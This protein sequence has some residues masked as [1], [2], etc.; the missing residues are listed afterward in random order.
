MA[1]AVIT[2]KQWSSK[3][4][5]PYL[6]G[7]FAPIDRVQQLKPCSYSGSIP[8]EL[9]GGEY[10]RNGGN[11]VQNQD[12]GR[13]AH[14]FDGD[15]MLSGVLFRKGKDGLIQP[16]F[17]NKYVLTDIY[18]STVGTPLLR[19]P[20]VPSIATLVN[21]ASSMLLLIFRILRTML[22]VLLSHLPGS[23]QAIKRLSPA[24]TALVFHDGRALAT[25]EL[26]PPIRVS[27]PSLETVGWFDG[28]KV[29]GE[30]A[31]AED[32]DPKFA[33]HGLFGFM[34][35]WTT[36]HPRVDPATNE[37]I[38]FHPNFKAPFVH[39][40]VLPDTS[41]AP[42]GT[43]SSRLV[44]AAVP[45][46]KSPKMMHDFGVSATHTVIMDLPLALDPRNIARGQPVVVYDP[47]GISRFGVFPRWNP[48]AVRW[49]ETNPCCIFHTANTW[50]EI[51]VNPHTKQ[52][53]IAAVNMLGCRLTSSALVFNAGNIATPIIKASSIYVQE[54]EQCRL[55]YYRFSLSD[56]GNKITHQFSLSAVPFE[57]PSL[58]ASAEMN[59]ARYIYGCSVS[60]RSYGAALGRAVK[61][62]SL[63]K[64][65]V[66]TLISR[67]KKSPPTSIIGCVDHRSVPEILASTDPE[68]PI[69]IFKLPRGLYA[70]ES[71]FV[72]RENGDSEDDGWLLFYVFD[73]SQLDK[74]GN[75]V[76]D[77]RSELWVL[78][79]KEMNEVVCKVQLPQRVPYGLHGKWFPESQILKQRP[80]ETLRHIP[81]PEKRGL[82]IGTGIWKRTREMI[83][84][85]VG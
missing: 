66:K 30:P 14:W 40:S 72:P 16:E 64:M 20:I 33:G 1:H 80:L 11:P 59:A 76:L 28:S 29:E 61:I 53:E 84:K 82:G 62:D 73:E 54:E 8:T 83:L 44:S 79:A 45:G 68:E 47:S 39:Y 48:Q 70:Q 49:F 78:E 19:Q 7:N 27:L 42:S 57:F 25:S 77:A 85:A 26:G 55:Y 81:V 32:P 15:G 43:K 24:N 6:E 41:I 58:R 10:V 38:L 56:F 31:R 23:R 37:L 65:D 46:I 69:K 13:D 17:V 75:A 60:D 36:A 18:I 22:L 2:E 5:H 52:N 63:V 67:A 34:E 9:A 50:D 71:Q 35:E 51:V 12:L 4:P 21:P 74:D 3:K